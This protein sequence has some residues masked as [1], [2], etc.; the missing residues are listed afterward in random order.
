MNV[1]IVVPVYGDW[2]SLSDCIDSLI[3]N[4]DSSVKV[5]LVNDCGPEANTIE[6][7]IA[8]KIKKYSNFIYHRNEKNLG[9]VKNCNNAVYNLDKTENDILLLNSDTVVT[10]GFLEELVHVLGIDKKHAAVSPRSNNATITTTPIAHMASKDVGA[11]AS[12]AHFSR[13]H[14]KRLKRFS[15]APVAHGFCML[16]RRSVIKKYGLFDEAFGMGYG[17]EVDFCL[18]VR[19]KGFKSVIANWSYV[20]HLEGKSFGIDKKKKL[21]EESSK[22]IHSR[23][24]KYKAEVR[25]YIHDAM[26]EEEFNPIRKF[27]RVLKSVLKD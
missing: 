19:Q 3:K 13:F 18:R 15:I 12:Y 27:V 9:F 26:I 16:I 24:P 6:K 22:I 2:P 7:N 1:T 5:M 11:E 17:E 10:D 21:I 25:A 14:R 8:K 23:Y 4:I 20:F